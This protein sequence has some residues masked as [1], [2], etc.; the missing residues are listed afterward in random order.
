MAPTRPD[1]DGVFLLSIRDRATQPKLGGPRFVEEGEVARAAA[2][3]ADPRTPGQLFADAII[4]VLQLGIDADPTVMVGQR[5]PA[6]RVIVSEEALRD[7]S[8]SDLSA[9]LCAT[10][11]VGVKFDDD[12][13]CVNVGR[14]Q[15]LFTARQRIGL[16]VREGGCRFPDCER[17]P[18][19]CE[20]HHIDYWHRDDGRTDLADGILLCRNHHP[21]MTLGAAGQRVIGQ[22]VIGQRV[23]GQ[24]VIGQARSGSA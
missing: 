24:R 3:A 9:H 16:A 7:R 1:E 17:P 19:W 22:C 21:L 13:Q 11:Q 4:G 6:V 12:G 23:I 14:D 15:R 5:R 10:G 18:S 20:A 2:I 8:V